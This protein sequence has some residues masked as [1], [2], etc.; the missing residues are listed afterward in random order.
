MIPLTPEELG[1]ALGVAPADRPVTGVSTDTRTL[2]PGDLFIALRGPAYDGHAFVPAAF[3]AG[4][5]GAVIEIGASVAGDRSWSPPGDA[6][7]YRVPDSVRALGAVARAVRRKSRA[8]V[9]AV[10]GSVGKT[11]TKDV[12]AAM[13]DVVGTVVAT[14]ANEN[15]EIGVP[16]TLLRADP[17]TDVIILEMGTRGHG[18]IR[19]LAKIAE[20][21]VGL[22][23]A[24]APVHLELLGS[25]ADVALAKAELLEELQAGAVGVI[26]ADAPL[27]EERVLL[28]G[29]PLVRFSLGEADAADVVGT[30]SDVEAGRCRLTVRWPEGEASADA[31]FAA[32]HRLENAV[33]AAAACYAAGF[34]LEKCVPA[35]RAAAFTPGRGDEVQ[36]GSWLILDDT[37]NANPTAM[38]VALDSVVERAMQRGGRAVAIVADMLELGTE[39]ERYHREM[40][41]YAAEAGIS[42]LVAHGSLAKSLVDGFES[43]VEMAAR[44]AHQRELAANKGEEPCNR[45][46]VFIEDLD[47]GLPTIKSYLRDGDSILIKASRGMR[48]ERVVSE[49]VRSAPDGRATG[50]SGGLV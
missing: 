39:A 30:V 47:Q 14:R 28:L 10:T 25:L 38:R 15:N 17:E 48:L 49:L 43:A 7:L 24:V 8:R 26:P 21:D 36:A 45:R 3:V 32:R 33:A 23:T 19:A 40:G 50:P 29:S 6:P 46:A 16:L 13:A 31:P 42:L 44:T 37:Y 9:I 1:L 18:Q 5:S 22:V 35:I 20:P 2:E 12:L 34:P 41:Q 27:L 4:A 11:G